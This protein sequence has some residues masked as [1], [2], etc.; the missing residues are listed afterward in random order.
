MDTLA[1]FLQSI[2]F[3]L[4]GL[5]FAGVA[6][7]VPAHPTIA[8][9]TA[10]SSITPPTLRP[11]SAGNDHATVIPEAEGLTPPTGAEGL[12]VHIE[13]IEVEGGFAEV[14]R[15]TGTIV[16]QIAGR[17]VTLAELYAAASAIEAAHARAGAFV[18]L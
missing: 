12:D 8:Q 11:P 5:L 18:S 10:P 17:R 13:R 3:D 6:S 2:T 7:F 14:A 15:E 1:R 4:V 9:S 16:A